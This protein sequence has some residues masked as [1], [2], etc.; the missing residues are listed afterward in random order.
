MGRT[1]NSQLRQFFQCNVFN[2]L[3]HLV[4]LAAEECA[5]ERFA[6]WGVAWVVGLLENNSGGD[7]LGVS[8]LG[9]W[10]FGVV[11]VTV[12]IDSL[13]VVNRVD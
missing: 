11:F 13:E 3:S 7:P 2:Y 12:D 8:L 10:V 4:L 1:C 6:L 5:C 9:M